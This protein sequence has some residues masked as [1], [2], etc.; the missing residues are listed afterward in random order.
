[1]I[2]NSRDLKA[3]IKQFTKG[4][5]L[6]SQSYLRSFFMERFLERISESPH[7]EIYLKRGTQ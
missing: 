1:M 3:K 4:D 5:S 6:K 2:R 7:K